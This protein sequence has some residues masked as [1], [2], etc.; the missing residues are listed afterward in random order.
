[1]FWFKVHADYVL[2]DAHH[3]KLLANACRALDVIEAASEEVKAKGLLIKNRFDEWREN[4]AANTERQTMHLFR[5]TVRELG[6]DLTDGPAG[7]RG[8]ARPGAR[9]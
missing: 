9:C 7:P 2:Q 6:L 5:Q 8:P 1:M 3:L 4:P